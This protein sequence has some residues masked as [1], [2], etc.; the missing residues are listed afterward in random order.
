M[1][2]PDYKVE[3]AV[4]ALRNEI[5]RDDF[6]KRWLCNQAMRAAL[7]A[8]EAAQEPPQ[9]KVTCDQYG[10]G[11]D[12][13]SKWLHKIPSMGLADRQMCAAAI[14]RAM[15]ALEKKPQAKPVLYRRVANTPTGSYVHY[16]EDERSGSERKPEAKPKTMA[17]VIFWRKSPESTGGVRAVCNERSGKE[18][19]RHREQTRW[20]FPDCKKIEYCPEDGWF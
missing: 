11:G 5:G 16:R 17:E 14:Y 13:L 15:R 10:A 8:A 18:R 19:R 4:E 7:E 2:I 9:I 1:T 6:N 12:V 20:H 3:A